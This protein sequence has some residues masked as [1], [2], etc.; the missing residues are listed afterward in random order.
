MVLIV[1]HAGKDA[2]RGER[3]HSSL[4]AALDVSLEVARNGQ[5][6]SRELKLSKSKNS[7]DGATWPFELQTII[8]GTDEDGDEITSCIAVIKEQADVVPKNWPSEDIPALRK[9]Q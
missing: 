9:F 4:R 3:G 8:L 2:S 6:S 1:H 7:T 5:Q